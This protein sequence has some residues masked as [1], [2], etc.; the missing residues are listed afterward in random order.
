MALGAWLRVSL[1]VAIIGLSTLL[2]GHASALSPRQYRWDELPGDAFNA[3]GSALKASV[4]VSVG[5]RVRGKAPLLVLL[6]GC[7]QDA[8]SFF[9]D[10]GWMD[11]ADRYGLIVLLPEQQHNA[12][13]M[14][15]GASRY[16]NPLGCFNFADRLIS[17]LKGGVPR[18]AGA[19]VS[20]VD[21][22]RAGKGLD[23]DGPRIE[24]GRV[25][26]TGLSAGAGMA[27]TLLADFPQ[28]FAGGALFAGVP[29]MCAQSMQSAASLCGISVSRGC[30][31]VKARSGGYDSREWTK[32][33]QRA[34]H[35]A[36]RPRVLIVQGTADCTV[37]P[38]NAL[39]LTNQWTAFHGLKTDAP[40]VIGQEP[41]WPERAVRQGYAPAG[42]NALWVET[43]L[44][45]DVGH[46]MPIDTH[47]PQR[48]C[49]RVRVSETKTYIEDIGFC[50][51]A[52]AA[53]FLQ[54]EQ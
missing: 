6:H 16:G 31:E 23:R 25:Y 8:S 9:T 39:Y 37:D 36:G 50:G 48:P 49:G 13:A 5:A 18:E 40:V 46:V 24:D 44:L 3:Q 2:S 22:V 1:A 38:Q 42:T 20:M 54:L 7:E 15:G 47:N 11:I 34:Q 43:V 19:I 17:P 51:A 53:G 28:V 35:P 45:K 14:V 33:V 4:Y 21:A 32:A 29:V 30:A 41:S 26:V 27:A 12:F 52:L 10:S